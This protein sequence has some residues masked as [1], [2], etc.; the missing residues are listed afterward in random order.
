MNDDD[1]STLLGQLPTQ[2]VDRFR[3]ERIRA[4][5]HRDLRSALSDH[6]RK[7]QAFEPLLVAAACVLYLSWAL[8]RAA[9]GLGG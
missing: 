1:L 3:A 4:L 6:R 5:A 7:L 8:M 9:A 2:D